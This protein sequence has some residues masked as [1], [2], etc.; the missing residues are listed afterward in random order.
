M[1]CENCGSKIP[2]TAKFC[3]FCGAAQTSMDNADVSTSLSPSAQESASVGESE[4]QSLIDYLGALH[5]AEMGVIHSDQLITLLDTQKAD[6]VRYH[7]AIW[8]AAS[9]QEPM[10]VRR[11]FIA[12][13]QERIRICTKSLEEFTSPNRHQPINDSWSAKMASLQM[14]KIYNKLDKENADYYRNELEKAKRSLRIDAPAAQQEEDR[15]IAEEMVKYN[16]RKQ[17]FEKHEALRKAAWNEEEKAVCL[18]F[19]ESRREIEKKRRDF[20]ACR[21][22]LYGEERLF[23]QFRDPVAEYT[24]RQ[25]LRMGLVDRL[26]GPQGGYAFYLNE[27]NAKRICG[28]I[29]EL[30]RSIENRLDIITGQLDELVSRMRRINQ[31]LDCLK[32]GISSCYGAIENGFVHMDRNMS[33]TANQMTAQLREEISRQ[34]QPIREAVQRSEY[35][36]YLDSMRK[37]LD[38]YQYG[39][40]RVPPISRATDL[41]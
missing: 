7:R 13:A 35:N 9:F 38:N 24:L 22:A 18:S 27:L 12:D 30:Q 31:Q 34:A 4:K 32:S 2:D 1:F 10:P 6:Y 16:L 36:L 15:R 28:S 39:R 37:E 41:F 29:Q 20:A 21:D 26:E 3:R 23:E 5:T 11:D 40:L 17:N 25:Y 14:R 8:R 33:Q 19:D